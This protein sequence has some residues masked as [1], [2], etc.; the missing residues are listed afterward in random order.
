MPAYGSSTG[1][2]GSPWIRL[3]GLAAQAEMSR[4][5]ATS[6]APPETRHFRCLAAF[7]ACVPDSLPERQ[8]LPRRGSMT[9]HAEGI[10]P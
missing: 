2:G 1:G 7:V 3:G 6:G 5:L 9:P 4:K 10:V 8:A